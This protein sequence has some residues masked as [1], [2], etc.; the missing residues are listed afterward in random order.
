MGADVYR[1][2]MVAQEQA[3]AAQGQLGQRV[4]GQG[5]INHAQAPA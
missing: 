4:K 5:V 3:A 2:Y 1:Q